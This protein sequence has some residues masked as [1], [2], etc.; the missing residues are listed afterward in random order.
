MISQIK[1]ILRG[2]NKQASGMD[3]Q[4]VTVTTDQVPRSSVAPE[5]TIKQTNFQAGTP[6]SEAAATRFLEQERQRKKQMP[7]YPG[8]E[9][10]DL[11]EK[12]GE[13]AFSIVY[14]AVEKETGK[15]VA[16]KIVRKQ[17]LDKDGRTHLH[18][19]MKKKPRA[20]EQ[21]AN[22]L[23]EVR[24]MQNARHKNLVQLVHFSE[25][26]E[27]YFLAM[28][29]CDGGELFHRIVKLTYFSES[30]A[31]HVIIQVADGI[32][33]LHEVCGV[34]HRDIKPENILFDSIPLIPSKR[35]V[36]TFDEDKEDEGVFTPG[37]GGGGIGNVK[38]ADFGLSKQIWDNS[39]LTPC[40]T[41]GY[42][43]PEIVRDQKYSKGVDMWAIGCV[44]YTMLCGFPPFYDESIRNLTEKVAR[45]QYTFLSPWWDPISAQA[46]D[47]ISHL[48]CVNPNDRYTI[49]EF[50][51]HPW[52]SQHI[53]QPINPSVAGIDSNSDIR[54]QQQQ[55]DS[56]VNTHRTT[57][58]RDV[59][60]PG[61]PSIKE[62]LDITYAVHRLG[63]ERQRGG[64]GGTISG[65]SEEEEDAEY[66]EVPAAVGDAAIRN[67][68]TQ[69]RQR[70]SP[71]Q[72]AQP[73]QLDLTKATLLQ[74]RKK[75]I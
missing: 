69:R 46:K 42:T 27:N 74:N 37:L 63:E 1:T 29:L 9:R 48:L 44:L 52:I 11:V 72:A 18:P 45:G 55:Q 3:D 35:P 7:F 15:K 36:N 50:F 61:V 66:E 73:F 13:G 25:S 68:Q 22:I 41:V 65:I 49:D 23:K 4:K 70:Q 67:I 53:P 17:E 47:L 32:R 62:I 2:K 19:N 26:K 6:A 30:L 54:L 14:K 20:T 28:E 10:F 43:A 8:L 34:V 75:A 31:R 51:Q 58:R 33:Y 12:L 5:G 24:I 40:G 39:T 64:G 57:Q 21:R 56:M 16:I 59:F 71:T 38:I 60:S